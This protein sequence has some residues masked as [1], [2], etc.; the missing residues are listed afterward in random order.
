MWSGIVAGV[1][2]TWRALRVSD[3]DAAAVVASADT[4]AT[5]LRPS[6]DRHK[7]WRVA[8]PS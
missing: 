1:V 6:A 5:M 3:V 8:F 4:A 2:T 7:R